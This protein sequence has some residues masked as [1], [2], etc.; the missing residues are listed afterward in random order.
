MPHVRIEM[1]K[2]KSAQYKKSIMDNIH[3]ALV[4][5]FKI[6]EIDRYF[7]IIEFDKENFFHGPRRSDDYLF[8]EILLFIGRSD[9]TKKRLYKNICDRL[10]KDL[11]INPIDIIIFLNETKLRNWGFA[12][13]AGD[14]IELSFNVNV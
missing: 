5:E 9:E 8:I 11:G 14:E 4:D 1:I 12:D 6:P 13:K 2:G 10:N 3:Y 7:R